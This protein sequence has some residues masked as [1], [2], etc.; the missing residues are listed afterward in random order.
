MEVD[1]YVFSK[2]VENAKNVR[3]VDIALGTTLG[4]TGS[5][6]PIY[7]L[8]AGFLALAEEEV[9]EEDQVIFASNSF[10]NMLRNTPELVKT[11][12]QDEYT[13]DVKFTIG[14]YEGRP[15]IP[16]PQN[17]F[18]TL[19]RLLQGGYGWAADA[20]NINFIICNK[21]AIYHVVK[22][23]KVRVF[24]PGVVQDFDG[25]KV[26]VRIY[27]DV[28]VPDRKKAAIYACVSSTVYNA[29]A[30]SER[31]LT[32]TY[33]A[34]TDMIS[35]VVIMPAGD[36]VKGLYASTASL[37][38]GSMVS[39]DVAAN[40]GVVVVGVATGLADG[41]YYL[42]GIDNGQVIAKGSETFTIS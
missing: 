34:A 21:K 22:Y 3:T 33:T 20:K 4:V 9:P 16:V 42:Y 30:T 23:D 28:F 1:A 26:N 2:L 15:I 18:R 6:Q 38:I 13:K 27:H 11:L 10:Y 5:A 19:I 24:N 12:R 41:T 35:D 40:K 32:F 8:N 25:Y 7:E 17:R 14:E 29:A 31:T 36:L 37:A 39:A